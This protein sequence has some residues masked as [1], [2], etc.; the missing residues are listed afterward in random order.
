[1]AERRDERDLLALDREEM[2]AL[3]CE[4]VD[5][6]VDL[7]AQGAP[8]RDFYVVVAGRLDV[9]VD[10]ERV[11][12][13]RPGDFFGE[14]AALDWGAGDAYPRLATVVATPARVRTI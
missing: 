1:M 9:P 14:P 10:S 6:L 13:L 7:V 11:R 5:L 2:R 8:S 12:T 3:G 4:A